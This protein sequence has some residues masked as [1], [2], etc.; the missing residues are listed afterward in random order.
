[1]YGQSPYD[2]FNL[3]TNSSAGSSVFSG[4]FSSPLIR[5]APRSKY[6]VSG[7]NK[8]VEVCLDVLRLYTPFGHPI[9][10]GLTIS[11]SQNAWNES[12]V[13]PVKGGF[14]I[15]TRNSFHTR[16]ELSNELAKNFKNSGESS[17]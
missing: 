11:A 5:Q 2:H 1:M 17:G 7:R 8:P 15:F 14:T 10:I 3:E 6:D 16:I 9:T 13:V 12:S 4:P